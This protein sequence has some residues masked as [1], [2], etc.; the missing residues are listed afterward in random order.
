MLVG[1]VTGT[2]DGAPPLFVF[3]SVDEAVGGMPFLFVFGGFGVILPGSVGETGGTVGVVV[4]TVTGAPVGEKTAEIVWLP[5][6]SL[7]V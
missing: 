6:T 7:K 1:A 3:G 5:A 2:V 4:A